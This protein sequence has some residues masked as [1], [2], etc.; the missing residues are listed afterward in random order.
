MAIEQVIQAVQAAAQTE[1]ESILAAAQKAADEKLASQRRVAEQ[2]AERRYQVLTR[3]IEEEFA[4]KLIQEQ[5]EA[6]KTL[7]TRKNAILRSIFSNA[8]EQIVALPAQ[9]YASIFMKLLKETVGEQGGSLVIHPD[10]QP[11]FESLAAEFNVGRAEDCQ[12]RI[13]TE[14]HLEAR[15]GFIFVTESFQVDQ[16]LDTLLEGIE[17]ELAPEIS[18]ALFSEQK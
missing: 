4:R 6:N 3:S 9:E 5:G 12:V 14:R 1:A 13:H 17:Y 8:R 16:S 7:L 11:V 2:D 15:G 18:A 10:E